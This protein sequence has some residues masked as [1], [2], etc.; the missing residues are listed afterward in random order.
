MKEN[1]NKVN[2]YA[3]CRRC[4]NNGCRFCKKCDGVFY[5]KVSLVPAT[6]PSKQENE[7]RKKKMLEYQKEYYKKH[8]AELRERRRKYFKQY[9]H[10]KIKNNPDQKER[11]RLR[12]LKYYYDHHEEIREKRNAKKRADWKDP[13]KVETLRAEHKQYMREYRAKKKESK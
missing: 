2:K 12:G 4:L 3:V 8:R 11:R 9:Y 1:D 7:D 5:F 13:A 10:E 6:V